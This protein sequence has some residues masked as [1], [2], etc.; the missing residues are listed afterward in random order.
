MDMPK[1]LKVQKAMGTDVQTYLEKRES[2]KL[3]LF[4]IDIRRIPNEDDLQFFD[5]I[6]H[7]Q[8]AIILVFTKADK[9]NQSESANT[10][11]ILE[12]FDSENFITLNIQCSNIL[13]EIN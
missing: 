5:W 12:T 6:V 8:L 13:G 1:F 7:H 9:V 3:I 2:F 11:K 4:L 10:K